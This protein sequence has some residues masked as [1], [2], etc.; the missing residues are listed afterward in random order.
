MADEEVDDL[1]D[2]DLPES[3]LE[4][5]FEEPEE[6]E[7]EENSKE[8]T[9]VPPAES[10]AK[11]E[12]E[13][14]PNIWR[15]VK[16]LTRYERARILA[17]RALQISMNAP[18]LVD[19]PDETDALAFAMKEFQEGLIPLT[20]RRQMPDGSYEDWD[21]AELNQKEV[22]WEFDLDRILSEEPKKIKP[23][24]DRIE[25]EGSK[26]IKQETDRMESKVPKR[27]EPKREQIEDVEMKT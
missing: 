22:E 16:K 7:E 25:S 26:K 21:V 14:D 20:I 17:T 11:E 1:I 15:P 5:D 23:E 13:S 12:N 10:K 8:I 18:V 19:M 2:L 6:E 4:L 24:M 9:E 27:K 3:D